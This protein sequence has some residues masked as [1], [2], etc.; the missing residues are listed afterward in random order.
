MSARS[1]HA[2]VLAALSAFAAGCVTQPTHVLDLMDADTD[3]AIERAAERASTYLADRGADLEVRR[4]A[5]KTLGRL[6]H[7]SPAVLGRLGAVLADDAEPGELRAYAAWALGEERSPGA[8]DELLRGLRG[9]VDATTGAYLLE[10]LAKHYALLS[11]SEDRLVEVVEALVYFAGNQRGRPP[12]IYDVLSARTRT[13]PVSVRVLDR[14]TSESAA[15]AGDPAATAAMY[16]ATYELLDRIA[17]S[18]PE[19]LADG[20]RWQTQLEVAIRTAHHAFAAE[21]PRTQ[22]MT[23][24]YLGQLAE[25]R[26]VAL[27]AAEV[28]VGPSGAVP[29]RPTLARSTA[30]RLLAAWALARLQL[31]A[32]GP[33]VALARDVLPREV[34][35]AVLRLLADLSRREGDLDQLQKILGVTPEAR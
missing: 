8:L 21:D 20:A 12:G 15:R 2:A 9:R 30:I 1:L 28:L 35:R 31:H 24:G 25:L 14:A 32:P 5:A 19:I 27:P 18:K 7:G 17:A 16:A 22:V 34:E 10:A 11:A 26:P 33:R 23:L 3:A 6:R 13:L 4:A 29:S